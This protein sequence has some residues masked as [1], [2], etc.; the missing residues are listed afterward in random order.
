MDAEK[1]FTLWNLPPV[2][3]VQ[4]KRFDYSSAFGQKINTMIGFEET[5]DM[6]PYVSDDRRV[7]HHGLMDYCLFG[8]LV[9]AGYTLHSGHYYCF[10]KVL[11]PQNTERWYVINDADVEEVSWEH[12]ARQNAYM[13]FYDQK[14]E[15]RHRSSR[16]PPSPSPDTPRIGPKHVTPPI[17]P[18]NPSQSSP[19]VRS[20]HCSPAM[21]PHS[22]RPVL[23]KSSPVKMKRAISDLELDGDANR[24]R[25][26]KSAR[27]AAE[28]RVEAILTERGW[29][30]RALEIAS[31]ILATQNESHSKS[32]TAQILADQA[33]DESMR[34]LREEPVL[35]LSRARTEAVLAAAPLNSIRPGGLL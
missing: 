29:R 23:G 3:V 1:Q 24:D 34:V 14:A 21:S 18:A 12:V 4:L 20:A 2:L 31:R 22:L 35:G 28:D 7:E 33:K 8:V 10:V 26:H 30:A 25:Q 27:E 32:V 9:H 13:L 19:R 16:R 6:S 11:C 15:P 17:R 5:L